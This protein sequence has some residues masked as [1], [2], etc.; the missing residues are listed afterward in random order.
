MIHIELNYT[1][2]EK[3]KHLGRTAPGRASE[4][5]HFVLMSSNPAVLMEV[6]IGITQI[7]ALHA[8]GILGFIHS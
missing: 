7:S 4:R 1:E 3:L 6:L 2:I 5:A 8:Q